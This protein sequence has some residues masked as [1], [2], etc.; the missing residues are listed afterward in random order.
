MNPEYFCYAQ[1]KFLVHFNKTHANKSDNSAGCFETK[2]NIKQY[3]KNFHI[4][5]SQTG[6]K[7]K[8]IFF[9]LLKYHLFSQD[10]KTKAFILQRN[11]ITTVDSFSTTR[12]LDITISI[13]KSYTIVF[14]AKTAFV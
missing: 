2:K 14:D 6:N 10:N 8:S 5:Y 13:L 12:V 11:L 1:H 3:E 4:F 9:L 7:M